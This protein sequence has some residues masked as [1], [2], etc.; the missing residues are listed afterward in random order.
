MIELKKISLSDLKEGVEVAYDGD[1]ELFEK[2][3]ILP[4]GFED[5]VKSTMEMIEEMDKLVNM[6]YYL[7]VYKRKIIGYVCKFDDFL[8][9]YGISPKYRSKNILISWWNEIKRLMPN[10]FTTGLYDNNSRAASFLIK[11]GMMF[12]GK[13]DNQLFFITK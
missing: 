12:V 13:K 11:N 9:S 6:D 7:V 10:V 5:C 4:M 2:Y 8:Y 3:H 1:F